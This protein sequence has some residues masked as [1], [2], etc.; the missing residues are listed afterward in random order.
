M[1]PTKVGIGSALLLMWLPGLR[2][3]SKSYGSKI[4]W[5]IVKLEIAYLEIM[6][7]IILHREGLGFCPSL[8]RTYS[9]SFCSE[10]PQSCVEYIY[11]YIKLEQFLK[12]P[13]IQ[14]KIHWVYYIWVGFRRQPSLLL[15]RCCFLKN[16]LFIKEIA[17]SSSTELITLHTGYFRD[18]K[19]DTVRTDNES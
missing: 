6:I 1:G 19:P 4:G 11:I 10:T 17:R 16:S 13:C 3:S 14:I 12:V 2:N 7:G 15:F 18:H 9:P 8:C 5:L